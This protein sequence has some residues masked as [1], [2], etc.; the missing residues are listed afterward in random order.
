MVTYDEAL[1]SAMGLG[2]QIGE[3]ALVDF[4]DRKRITPVER[5]LASYDGQWSRLESSLLD[6]TNG[7]LH[8]EDSLIEYALSHGS[9]KNRD[10][11]KLLHRASEE[12]KSS[13][14]NYKKNDLR[15]S[16]E[17]LVKMSSY[18]SPATLKEFLPNE[19]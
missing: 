19:F 10:S 17:H 6:L 18:W 3:K 14:V 16:A 2:K 7:S 13:L 4:I 5:Y 9:M 15:S 8:Y 1:V 11:V 12:L